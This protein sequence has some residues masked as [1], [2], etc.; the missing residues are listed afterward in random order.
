LVPDWLTQTAHQC[1][2]DL[3]CALSGGLSNPQARILLAQVDAL[4]SVVGMPKS[5]TGTGDADS[6]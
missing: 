6:H 5:S 2:I 3:D 1:L 4:I